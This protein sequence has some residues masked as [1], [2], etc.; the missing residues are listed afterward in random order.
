MDW[1]PNTS[2]SEILEGRTPRYRKAFKR[3]CLELWS[4]LKTLF[5][6]FFTKYSYN[7][8]IVNPGGRKTCFH[9]MKK[10][11]LNY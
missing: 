2:K 6:V 7:H 10:L 8:S 9:I 5:N 3:D 11:S 1:T 4:N